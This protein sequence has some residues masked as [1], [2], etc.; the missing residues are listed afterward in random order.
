MSV[1]LIYEYADGSNYKQ[2]GSIR[3]TEKLT[4]EQARLIVD[5]LDEEAYFIPEQVGI[6][7]LPYSQAG[8]EDDHPWH[9]LSLLAEAVEGGDRA[10]F[11]NYSNKYLYTYDRDAVVSDQFTPKLL[12]LAFMDA[13]AAGWDELAYS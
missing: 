2:S 4:Y 3:L 13:A 7:A 9:N 11:Q 5:T 12:I 1:Y 6:P 10:R 8:T